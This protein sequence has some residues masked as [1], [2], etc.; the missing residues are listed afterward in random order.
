[1]INYS[2]FI[3]EEILQSDKNLNDE[4]VGSVKSSLQSSV[5]RIPARK[6]SYSFFPG[7]FS[8]HWLSFETTAAH[9]PWSS[10]WGEGAGP[11]C[12]RWQCPK[13]W[14]SGG[15]KE[16][17]I[18]SQMRKVQTSLSSLNAMI[19]TEENSIFKQMQSWGLDAYLIPNKPMSPKVPMLTIQ[20]DNE[21]TL[22]SR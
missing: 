21:E 12:G 10:W 9:N 17:S 6:E 22:L 5:L 13:A 15:G 18:Q 4:P 11:A 3:Y 1:M 14:W 16:V 7:Q 2:Y 20:T 8:L 19:L